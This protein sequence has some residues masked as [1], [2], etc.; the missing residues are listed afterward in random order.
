MNKFDKVISWIVIIISIL[1]IVAGV[2]FNE[3]AFIIISS[4]TCFSFTYRHIFLSKSNVIIDDV[5]DACGKNPKA[6]NS[7]ICKQCQEVIDG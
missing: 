7:Q 4:I 6:P 3:T 1:G 5:C 2:I